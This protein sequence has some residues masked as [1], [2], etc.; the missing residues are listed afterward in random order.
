MRSSCCL[1]PGMEGSA[2]VHGRFP[3]DRQ[4]QVFNHPSWK[5]C[6]TFTLKNPVMGEEQGCSTWNFRVPRGLFFTLRVC[7][8]DSLLLPIPL[9]Y[10]LSYSG[11]QKGRLVPPKLYR[12]HRQLKFPQPICICLTRSCRGAVCW[13]ET[14]SAVFKRILSIPFL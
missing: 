11:S 10:C 3:A 6:F 8:E 5:C 1:R 7:F 12:L 9:I 14:Q 2:R 13:E 4:E